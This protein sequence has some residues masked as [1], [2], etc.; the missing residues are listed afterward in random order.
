MNWLKKMREQRGLTQK[1]LSKKTGVN[2]FTIQNIEQ[3]TRK[4]STKTI[5]ILKNFFENDESIINESFDCEE[6]IEELEEDIEEFG[7]IDLFAEFEIYND[8]LYLTNYDF[9]EEDHSIENSLSEEILNKVKK[10][11]IELII[12]KATDILKI[13]KLQNKII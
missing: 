7:D 4:G 9:I 5:E 2:I 12:M 6:L 10:H 1:E 3:E 8:K 11:E 13:L